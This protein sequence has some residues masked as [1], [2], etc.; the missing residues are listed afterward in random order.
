M[1]NKRFGSFSSSVNPEELSKTV[2][3]VFKTLGVI[4]SSPIVIFAMT[5]FGLDFSFIGVQAASPEEFVGNLQEL[6]IALGISIALL[7]KSSDI[8]FGLIRKLFVFVYD[9]LP[10]KSL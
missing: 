2:E 9:R 7:V 10:V 6:L 4:I 5:H 3:G 1:Q 8:A